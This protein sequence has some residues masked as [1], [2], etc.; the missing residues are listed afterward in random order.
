MIDVLR[1]QLTETEAKQEG[2]D[3]MYADLEKR[4]AVLQ[5]ENQK[6]MR[7]NNM[8]QKIDYHLQLKKEVNACKEEIKTLNIDKARLEKELVLACQR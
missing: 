3:A 7:N 5:S 1:H 2:V 8:K 4:F 6:L